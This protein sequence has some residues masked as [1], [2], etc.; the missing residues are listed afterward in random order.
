MVKTVQ[1]DSIR[2]AF[3]LGGQS[4]DYDYKFQPIAMSTNCSPNGP[5]VISSNE[6][7]IH[8]F[9]KNPQTTTENEFVKIL[10]LEHAAFLL[11]SILRA[12]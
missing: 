6:R 3:C 8:F 11:Q 1:F 4:N 7:E 9:H 10:I 5:I 2:F 12:N